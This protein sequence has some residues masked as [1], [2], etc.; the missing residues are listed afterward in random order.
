MAYSSSSLPITAPATGFFQEYHHLKCGAVAL[1][2]YQY[3]S[4]FVFSTARM[5]K[6]KSKVS[7]SSRIIFR[8]NSQLALADLAPATS[9][10]YGLLLLG[11][12]LFAYTKSGS[13]GSLFG[14]TTGAA[15]MASIQKL[16]VMLLGLDPHSFSLLY[17]LYDWQLHVS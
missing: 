3:A 14:G 6:S 12:G 9:A 10:A 1:T 8:C 4:S 16:L 5:S 13:K 17:L 15:L 2:G 7:S 11:G